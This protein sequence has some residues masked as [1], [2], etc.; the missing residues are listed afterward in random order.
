[1]TGPV[2]NQSIHDPLEVSVQY[3]EQ[4]VPE[5]VRVKL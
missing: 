2:R 3:L 4:V 1:M 5:P